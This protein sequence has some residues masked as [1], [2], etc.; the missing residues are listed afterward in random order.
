MLSQHTHTLQVTTKGREFHD[1]TREV[2]AQVK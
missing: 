2:T 1:I